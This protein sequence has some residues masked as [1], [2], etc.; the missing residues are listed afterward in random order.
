MAPV[1]PAA[2]ASRIS[3]QVRSSMKTERVCAEAAVAAVSRATAIVSMRIVIPPASGPRLD[4][5]RVAF[6]ETSLV[7]VRIRWRHGA[8][9]V[10][11]G[12]VVRRQR[13]AGCAQILLQLLLGAGPDDHR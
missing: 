10:E 7:P 13:P 2:M 1:F 3:N 9:G 11:A 12:D 4:R 8:G 6:D 5:R